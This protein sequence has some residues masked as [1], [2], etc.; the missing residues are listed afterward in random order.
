MTTTQPDCAER[1]KRGLPF[2]MVLLSII[3]QLIFTASKLNPYKNSFYFPVVL[4]T[5]FLYG[6]CLALTK[7]RPVESRRVP[8]NLSF[9]HKDVFDP[10]RCLRL[11]HK[12]FKTACRALFNIHYRTT[13]NTMILCGVYLGNTMKNKTWL[14]VARVLEKSK[15]F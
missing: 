10:S 8:L 3:R 1:Q 13:I 14:N 9:I 11:Q 5:R 12:Y 6:N 15:I 2:N 4:S 7:L